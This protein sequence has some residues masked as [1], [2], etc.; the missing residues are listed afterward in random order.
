MVD[1]KVAKI[2]AGGP[3]W[4]KDELVYVCTTMPYHTNSR[5]VATPQP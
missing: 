3:E 2:G 4:I 1:D 5:M